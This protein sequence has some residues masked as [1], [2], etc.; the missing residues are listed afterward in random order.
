MKWLDE[1]NE[2][3]FA[4]SGVE[5]N[6]APS[7]ER[8]KRRATRKLESKQGGSKYKASDYKEINPRY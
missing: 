1:K 6:P 2:I 4:A 7:T 8:G 3:Q 5:H